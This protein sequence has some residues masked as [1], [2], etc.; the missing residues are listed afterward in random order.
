M[1]NPTKVKIFI[2]SSGELKEERTES[3]LLVNE[4]G[5][6]YPHLDLEAVLFEFDTPSGNVLFKKRIQDGI[7]PKL[8]ESHIAV[9][10]FYTKAGEFTLEEMDLALKNDKKVFVYFKEGFTPKS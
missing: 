3:I 10:M 8:E 6:H 5:K 1:P 2:A 4:L 9:V 7:N